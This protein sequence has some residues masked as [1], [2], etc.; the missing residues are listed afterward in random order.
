M[1][2]GVS[3]GLIITWSKRMKPT[4]I[5]GYT[6]IL[7]GSM[8]LALMRKSLPA[9]IYTCLIAPACLGQG[10]SFPSVTMALLMISHQEDLA[11]AIST[12]MLWRSLGTVMGVAVSSLIMQNT[13]LY[14]LTQFVTGP[15]KE[16]V[17]HSDLT[18]RL[19]RF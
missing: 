13:L 18:Q 10:F 2:A 5:L 11:I 12:L 17:I 9:W 7:I 1:V 19:G 8:L 16:E 4:L 14:Y 15:D 3:T 6:L